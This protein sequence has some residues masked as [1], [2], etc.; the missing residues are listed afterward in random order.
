[1]IVRFPNRYIA[2]LV[3]FVILYAVNYAEGLF[4]ANKMQYNL[5]IVIQPRAASSLSACITSNDLLLV[6]GSL[7][8]VDMVVL[9]TGFQRNKDAL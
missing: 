3:P 1:M 6:F 9:L 5:S 7:F 8:I 4:L 2:F